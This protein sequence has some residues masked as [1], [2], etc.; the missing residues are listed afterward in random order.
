MAWP[1]RK[2][3]PAEPLP[4]ATSAEFARRAEAGGSQNLV[5]ETA[6]LGAALLNRR[7][8]VHRSVKVN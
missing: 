6:A 2:A 7:Y 4:D 1:C 5:I 3:G 8:V